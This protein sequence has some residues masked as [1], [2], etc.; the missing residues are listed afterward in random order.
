VTPN[1]IQESIMIHAPIER[2]FALSTRIQLV[3]RILGMKPIDG[4]TTGHIT[5]NSRITWR[6]WKFGLPTTH[7]TLITAFEPPHLLAN[8]KEAF[9]QDTQERGRFAFFQHDHF[10]REEIKGGLPCTTLRDAVHFSLPFGSLGL[11]LA[12]HLLSPHIRGLARQRFAMLKNLAE[13]DCWR[14]WV[15]EVPSA[16]SS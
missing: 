7:H 9:F 10:L 16:A 4:I 8:A 3:Q 12:K 11:L 15:S 5:A 2:C 1:I 6:G 13:G 14:E